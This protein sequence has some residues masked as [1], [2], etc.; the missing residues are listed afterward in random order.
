MSIVAKQRINSGYGT[1]DPGAGFDG[2]PDDVVA[3]W[4]EAGIAGETEP[5]AEPA[6]EPEPVEL[7][8]A[9]EPAG[10]PAVEVGASPSED[11]E[12]DPDAEPAAG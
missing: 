9:D 3:T 10:T 12:T 2:V 11:P 4:V 8:P 6:A 7:V 1:F 5:A